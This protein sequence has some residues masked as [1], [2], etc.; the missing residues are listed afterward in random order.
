MTLVADRPPRGDGERRL[1]GLQRRAGAEG[2]ELDRRLGDG[3]RSPVQTGEGGSEV[4]GEERQHS[5]RRALVGHGILQ[6][7]SPVQFVIGLPLVG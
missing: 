7:G 6:D 1:H 2:Q 4:R 5:G 3:P